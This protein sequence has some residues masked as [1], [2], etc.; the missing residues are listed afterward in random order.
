VTVQLVDATSGNQVWGKRYDAEIEN[1]FE[2]E[3]E[4]SRTIATTVTGQ[5]ESDLQ[6]IAIAKGAV[7]QQSYD[8]LL[9]GIYHSKKSTAAGMAIAIE[10]LSQCLELDPG[11]ALAHATLYAC[12]EMNWIDRWVADFEAS[13][14][15]CKVH[16]SKALELNPELGPVQVAFAEYLIFNRDYEEAETHLKRALEIN[17]NDSQAIAAQAL[18]LSSQGKFEAAV[19]KARL[20]LQLDPYHT[21]AR[22]IL[23]EAQF[24]CGLYEEVLTTIAD[25][26]NPPDSVTWRPRKTR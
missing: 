14:K 18:N 22:W 8:L 7:H 24:F 20:A 1:L 25:T 2:L 19:E 5:I 4:L 6:R 23:S 13:R 3:E 11:N 17:P 21:W 16:A 12:H 10:K 9:Q 15:L 26:G